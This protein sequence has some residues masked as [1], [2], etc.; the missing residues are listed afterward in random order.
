MYILVDDTSPVT[1]YEIALEPHGGCIMEMI[2]WG[3][4]RDDIYE[5]RHLM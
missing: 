2:A 5:V 1:S 4:M 3:V